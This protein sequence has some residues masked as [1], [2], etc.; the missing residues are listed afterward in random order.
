MLK[1]FEVTNFKNFKEKFVFDLSDTKGYAFNEECVKDGIVKTGLIYGA[2]GCGKSNLGYAIMDIKNHITDDKI[3][4]VYLNNKTYSNADTHS[5]IAEF[6]YVFQFGESTVEYSYGK[7]AANFLLYENVIIDGNQVLT[8]DR[9][10]SNDAVILLKGAET[11]NSSL[12]GT[13][14]SIIK[15]VVNNS[16]LVPSPQN[17]VFNNFNDF[18]NIIRPISLLNSPADF[19]L[20]HEKSFYDSI[21]DTEQGYTLDQFESFLNDAGVKCN[22]TEIDGHNGSRIAFKFKHQSLDFLMNASKGTL[23]LSSLYEEM[24]LIKLKIK[25]IR[26]YSQAF[27]QDL[28]NAN[29]QLPI[30]KVQ[31]KHFPFVFIDEFDAFYHHAVSK[32][33]VKT[34]RDMD[35]QVV[36]TTHNTSIMTNDLLRPDCNFLMQKD[37]VKPLHRYTDRE[38]RFAHN[39]EKMYKAG[40]FSE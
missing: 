23:V 15:Y 13:N 26:S 25:N 16:L 20:S 30:D 22:L 31:Y 12:P 38:L 9:R 39:I 27:Q 14:V 3:P 2:N 7:V 1:R 5:S 34:F 36:F 35:V 17:I 11:L 32:L 33:I 37:E 6:T 28:N 19:R 21:I 8:I 10:K 40:V 24:L 4:E 29:I 18:I